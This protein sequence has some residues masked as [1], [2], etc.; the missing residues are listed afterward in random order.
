MPDTKLNRLYRLADLPPVVGLKRTQIA[1]LIENGEFPKP[2]SLSDT[3]RAI[4]WLESDLLAWQNARI[5]LR[6][7]RKS[8]D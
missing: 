4:A 6:N 5:S 8:E 7:S 1:K 3:G 2:I